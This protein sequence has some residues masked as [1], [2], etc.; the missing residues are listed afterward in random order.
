M[1]LFRA[2]LFLVLSGASLALGNSSLFTYEVTAFPQIGDAC[3]VAAKALGSRLASAAGVEVVASGCERAN[4]EGARLVV[5]YQ[6]RVDYP[7][8]ETKTEDHSFQ[9]QQVCEIALQ[10]QVD[11]FEAQTKL[12]SILSFC[13]PR[14]TLHIHAVGIG[15]LRPHS[16]RLSLIDSLL[17]R[18]LLENQAAVTEQIRSYLN[19]Q[20]KDAALGAH[21]ARVAFT[22]DHKLEILYYANRDLSHGTF[23]PAL[24]FG[25]YRGIA[26]E[27]QALC[28]AEAERFEGMLSALGIDSIATLCVENA[29]SVSHA[30]ILLALG[31]QKNG[32]RGDDFLPGNL[33]SRHELAPQQFASFDECEAG[34]P[35]IEGYYRTTLGRKV[36][37][38]LCSMQRF[39]PFSYGVLMFSSN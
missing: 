2:I 28:K 7:V 34:R 16:L 22:S 19:E 10:E 3:A 31:W 14:G 17:Y 35:S 29:G 18:P 4:T 12:S 27:N 8:L 26:F 33:R 23:G 37:G 11:I 21:F 39:E 25:F 30:N 20:G 36:V 15:A 6:S 24:P 5:Q 32:L 13:S 38:S 9:N 1:N